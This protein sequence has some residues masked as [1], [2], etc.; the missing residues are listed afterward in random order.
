MKI[1]ANISIILF[2]FE[3]INSEL[4]ETQLPVRDFEYFLPREF[5]E[6]R[7]KIKDFNAENHFSYWCVP[8]P[9]F[10]PPISSI[11]PLQSE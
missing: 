3:E 9:S 4:K 11:L 10:K 8:F 7:S 5:V 6:K 2:F 1:W